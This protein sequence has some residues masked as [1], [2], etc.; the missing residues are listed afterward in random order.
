MRLIPLSTMSVAACL[1]LAPFALAQSGG[2]G[3]EK[4]ERAMPAAGPD[5]K[6]KSERAMEGGA[7]KPASATSSRKGKSERAMP[8]TNKTNAK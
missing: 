4:K 1:L 2:G 5:K 7:K 6:M 3:M 8:D